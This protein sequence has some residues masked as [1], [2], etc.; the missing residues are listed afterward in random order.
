MIPATR[1]LKKRFIK[2]KWPLS[3]ENVKINSLL[4]EIESG[5]FYL[6]TNSD[7][8]GKVKIFLKEG[9]IVKTNDIRTITY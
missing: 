5:Y 4:V 1:S 7:Y 3:N 9:E 6:E 8:A 2:W